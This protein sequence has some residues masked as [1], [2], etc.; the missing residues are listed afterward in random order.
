MHV[1]AT[2]DLPFSDTEEYEQAIQMIGKPK[3]TPS[4]PV[5]MMAGNLRRRPKPVTFQVPNNKR[6]LQEILEYLTGKLAGNPAANF[7]PLQDLLGEPRWQWTKVHDLNL[8]YNW[9]LVPDQRQETYQDL[10][11]DE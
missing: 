4:V 9:A 1:L 2:I 8:M 7:K 10:G 3:D 5:C 11:D 6:E